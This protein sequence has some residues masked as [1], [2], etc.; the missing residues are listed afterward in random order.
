MYFLSPGHLY[1][2]I[3]RCFFFNFPNLTVHTNH[4]RNVL[5]RLCIYRLFAKFEKRAFNIPAWISTDSLQ[6]DSTKVALILP[7]YSA[8]T[9]TDV[10]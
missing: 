4:I 7:C 9:I 8:K 6:M 5:E 2:G 1:H 10:Q 3:F